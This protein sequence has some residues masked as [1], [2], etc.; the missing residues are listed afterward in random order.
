MS[1]ML[2][3]EF[4]KPRSR[5]PEPEKKEKIENGLFTITPQN[6]NLAVLVYQN[7]MKISQRYFS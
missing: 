4:S 3:P 6:L 5:K 1:L 2:K 7:M